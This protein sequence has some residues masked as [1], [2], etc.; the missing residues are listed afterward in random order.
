LRV[1]A[2]QSQVRALAVKEG[3]DPTDI[4][5]FPNITPIVGR[6]LEEAQAKYEIAKEYADWEGG[7]ACVSGFSG[8]DLSQF[9]LDEPFNFE[10]LMTDNSVH[11]MIEAV[12]R[13]LT[14]NMTPRQLGK[15]FAFCGFGDMPVGTPDMIAD[16]IEEWINIA[17]IDGFIMCCKS[18]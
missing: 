10:G 4:N 18:I 7:L 3:R 11:T 16:R 13:V 1:L 8:L 9:P 15:E 6:T 17:D 14:P 2:N 5:F 12:K